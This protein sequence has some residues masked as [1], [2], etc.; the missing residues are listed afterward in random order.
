MEREERDQRLRAV[1][2]AMA[3][4]DRGATFDLYAEFGG[5]IG[6]TIRRLLRRLGV[7]SVPRGG[8][9]RP[10]DR[11]LPG[12]LQACA[13][14]WD[15]EGGAV[16][17]VWAER[18]LLVVVSRYVG[19]H[20]DAIDDRHE[21]IDLVVTSSGAPAVGR[22]ARALARLDD[23]TCRLLREALATV[24]SVR[25]QTI[26][27]EVVYSAALGDTSPA[28]TIGP[29]VGLRPDAVRQVLRRLRQRLATL[30]AAEP[31]YARSSISSCWRSDRRTSAPWEPSLRTVAVRREGGPG[32]RDEPGGVEVDVVAPWGA[33]VGDGGVERASVLD[34]LGGVLLE[35]DREAEAVAVV[36]AAREMYV[37]ADDPA[38]IARCD[39]N[40]GLLLMALDRNDEAMEHYVDACAV[41]D[42]SC[43]SPTQ[44][45][46]GRRWPSCG[47]SPATTSTRWRC[48]T[49]RPAPSPRRATASARAGACSTPPRC[50]STSAR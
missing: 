9:R 33:G 42:E 11:C 36:E 7:E 48:S 50:W 6:A 5:P 39:R 1:M 46:A 23:P 30:A 24:A 29:H 47:S 18:R 44:P 25:E 21:V 13:E 10:G 22:A 45:G 26:L 28:V 31:R 37:E 32:M 15:P 43:C 14:S 17:W 27:L 2:A 49:R 35:A 19:Q 20:A 12:G 38:E 34:E 8:A 40:L 41:Y 4:G 3:A 16:P